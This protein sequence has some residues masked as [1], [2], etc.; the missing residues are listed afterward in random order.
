MPSGT[1]KVTIVFVCLCV[2]CVLYYLNNSPDHRSSRVRSSETVLGSWYC[3]TNT[4]HRRLSCYISIFF[5]IIMYYCFGRPESETTGLIRLAPAWRPP[6][7]VPIQTRNWPQG[8][9]Q[10][11][12]Q[13]R[14][15][16]D[17][18]HAKLAFFIKKQRFAW[19]GYAK[20]M[21][22]HNFVIP[23]SCETS[24]FIKFCLKTTFRMK[25]DSFAWEG[26]QYMI[27]GIPCCATLRRNCH[28]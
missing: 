10:K 7:W 26:S 5:D 3:P 20:M 16:C 24:F 28:F 25:H 15:F 23:L 14:I 22:T 6:F 13:N 8:G 17:P 12:H 1:R 2:V 21:N 11:S 19:E 4:D 18:S 9:Y 27:R